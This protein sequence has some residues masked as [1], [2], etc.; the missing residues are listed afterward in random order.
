MKNK[1]LNTENPRKNHYF[2]SIIRQVDG[3]PDYNDIVFTS[4]KVEDCF[5]FA[6]NNYTR[7]VSVAVKTYSE[8]LKAGVAPRKMIDFQ[9]PKIY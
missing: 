1:N 7:S 4:K 9:N 3:K 2:V 5:D 8:M 6:R